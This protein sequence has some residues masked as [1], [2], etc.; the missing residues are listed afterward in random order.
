MEQKKFLSYPRA[1]DLR[2]IL[3]FARL[4]HES[5]IP[6]S[7]ISKRNLLEKLKKGI[8]GQDDFDMLTSWKVSQGVETTDILEYLYLMRRLGIVQERPVDLALDSIIPLGGD[9]PTLERVLQSDRGSSV[10]FLSPLGEKLLRL[11]EANDH[12]N[13]QDYLFWTVLRN[14]L[15]FP[16]FQEIFE[17]PRSYR[18][19]DVEAIIRT[20]DSIT[21]NVIKHWGK[22]FDIFRKQGLSLVL[23][24]LKLAHYIVKSSIL[25]L[26]TNIELKK[27]YYVKELCELLCEAF[28][29][30]SSSIDFLFVLDLIYSSVS[31]RIVSG[32]T[33]G[34]GDISLPTHDRIQILKFNSYIPEDMPSMVSSSSLNCFK[35][36]T[37]KGGELDVGI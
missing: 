2:L 18:G 5:P 10:Q 24:D 25:E 29:L 22:F 1:Y 8:I 30:Q 19:G 16:I 26:N 28:N 32:F 20:K 14:K 33:S 34:R 11:A 4:L 15:M 27:Q 6:I 37:Y 9:G 7:A 21:A 31:R 13:L 23:D 12:G 17:D 3:N 36:R 35:F